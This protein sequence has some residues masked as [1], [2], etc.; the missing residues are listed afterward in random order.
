MEK[1]D[2]WQIKFIELY[3]QATIK[4]FSKTGQLVFETKGYSSDWDGKYQGKN[5]PSGSYMYIIDL[6]DGSDVQRGFVDIIR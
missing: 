1:N 4:V 5:L 2:T 6:N 3:P